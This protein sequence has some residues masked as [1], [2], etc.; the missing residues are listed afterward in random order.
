VHADKKKITNI[1]AWFEVVILMT[2][3]I[4]ANLSASEVPG[5]SKAI[6]ALTS[7]GR[8]DMKSLWN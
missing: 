8:R 2:R 3:C 5:H 6:Q 7:F 1:P 4:M